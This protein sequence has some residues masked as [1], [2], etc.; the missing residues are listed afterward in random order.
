MPDVFISYS[1][2][3]KA[4]VQVLHQALLK[5]NYDSW[6]DWEDIPLTADW[7]EE[8]KAG[9][10]SADTFVFV[11][12]PDSIASQICRQEIDYAV[13]HNKRLV[14][15]VRREGFDMTLVHPTLGK[16]NWLFFQTN[17]DFD[18]AFQSLVETLNTDLIYVKAHTKLLIRALEWEH[19][20]K[21]DDVLLRG[22]ELTHAQNWLQQALINA[23]QPVPTASQIAF[24]Q[25]SQ[26]LSDCLLKQE[27]DHQKQ[28]LRQARQAALGAMIV[29]IVMAGL[30][31]FAI[32]QKRQVETVQESQINALSRYSLSLTE[33]RQSFD[34]LLEA[35]RAGQQ[36]QKQ[37]NRVDYK[38][39][40][41]ALTALQAAVYEDG[42]REHNR[43]TGHTND[44]NR[45][46]IS[47]DGK[48]IASASRDY[49]IRLWDQQGNLLKT[50]EGHGNSVTS[51][52]FSPNGMTLASTSADRTVK[53]WTATG[54]L[55]RTLPFDDETKDVRFSPDGDK[56]AIATNQQVFLTTPDGDIIRQFP[57]KT[58]VNSVRFSAD[59]QQLLTTTYKATQLWTI[60]GEILHILPNDDW[61]N[62]AQFSPQQQDGTTIIATAGNKAVQL[63]TPDGKLLRTLPHNGWVNSVRFSPDGRYIVTADS[64]EQIILWDLENQTSVAFPQD[65]DTVDA[66]FSTDAQALVIANRDNVINL[67][68]R[69]ENI[70]TYPFYRGNIQQLRFNKDGSLIATMTG[71]NLDLWSNTGEILESWSFDHPLN[72]IDFGI[73]PISPGKK[74][75]EIPEEII[76]SAIKNQVRLQTL[77]GSQLHLWEYADPVSSVDVSPDG[78]KVVVASG[79]DVYL[80]SA[81]GELIQTLSGVINAQQ[82][83]K[84]ETIQTST[85]REA[86]FSPDG[87]HI[88]IRPQGTTV[89][90]WHLNGKT[91]DEI[92]SLVHEDT[93][94]SFSFNPVASLLASGSDDNT[95]RLWNLDGTPLKRIDNETTF[96][97]IRFS[98][99]GKQLA[100]VDADNQINV[101]A[102]EKKQLTPL[103]SLIRHTNRINDL[104]F[105]PN[106]THLVSAGADE[107][108]I[109]WD[110]DNL[111]LPRL[112]H[113][114]CQV[115]DDY[116]TT[117]RQLER[118]DQTLCEG[119]G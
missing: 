81:T 22:G 93:V 90:I 76:A 118:G 37:L 84:I 32:N 16:S 18:T 116:L 65:R 5:S 26:A 42:W 102:V 79:T 49:T 95:L 97:K 2:R 34:A 10:E 66:I 107:R 45:L 62:M 70:S 114:A 82:K 61:V 113:D 72:D 63:W 109:V 110:L 17:N 38:T 48:L 101:W 100:A 99:N 3:D 19:K 87:Q 43:L 41:L 64:A 4:F 73:Q 80:V 86:R 14:P 50:L 106:S 31:I 57:H 58:W 9:I 94:Q 96:N 117:N 51:V 83:A 59:G 108:V 23:K 6:V 77:N 105:H 103:I 115:V 12:S 36:L 44:V 28:A 8:I 104:D 54:N 20:A 88:A 67:W 27:Q 68:R 75:K 89:H 39:H 13:E 47:P 35:L 11:I 24:I 91:S 30:A 78:T 29:G 7:W 21:T 119:I 52:V 85:I 112:M 1:R 40:S 111:T 53:L 69:G 25:A 60:N 56:I 55:V 15:I 46:A 92:T 74:K 71:T 33:S 98:A